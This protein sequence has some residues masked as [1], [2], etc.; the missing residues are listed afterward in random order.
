MPSPQMISA[1][2]GGGDL[3]DTPSG[4]S[5]FSG[6]GTGKGTYGT[7]A[8]GAGDLLSTFGSLYA[9]AMESATLT[10]QSN[11]QN[12]NAQL[13]IE[14]GASNAAR[15]QIISGQKIGAIQGA[16]AA[17]GVTQSGSVLS[18][19]A[20]SSMNAEMDRQNVLY[21]EQVK[22]VQE[23]NQASMDAYGAQSAQQ[24]SYFKA[25]G[26]A[27]GAGIAVAALL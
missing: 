7:V 4:G 23:E 14:A 25:A 27:V 26:G 18:I 24:G 22:A 3:T 15:S 11:I 2:G 9:G 5:D 12:Q 20:A 16:A 1:D 17:S 10:A 6:A 8:T 21:G 13:D 19:M